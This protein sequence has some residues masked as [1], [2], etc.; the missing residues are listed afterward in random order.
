MIDI[1]LNGNPRSLEG[2]CDL[3]TFIRQFGFTSPYLAIAVNERVVPRANH[4]LTTVK[5]GDRIEII[6]P[7]GGG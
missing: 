7:V 5:N 3:V 2:E 6:E 4:P 1:T